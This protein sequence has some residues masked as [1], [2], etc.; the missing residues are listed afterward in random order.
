MRRERS[1]G[2]R[3]SVREEGRKSSKSSSWLLLL[4]ATRGFAI[5]LAEDEESCW[6]MPHPLPIPRLEASP[7]ICLNPSAIFTLS[8]ALTEGM[9]IDC[10]PGAENGEV[11]AA[12]LVLVRLREE[13]EVPGEKPFWRGGEPMGPKSWE[14]RRSA[15]R[16]GWL[17]GSGA[18]TDSRW[19]A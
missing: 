14:G 9:N 4:T 11:D 1:S 16:R 3:R 7:E 19:I 13:G 15:R 10:P 18:G 6:S 5:D 12:K 17:R 2:V 8:S